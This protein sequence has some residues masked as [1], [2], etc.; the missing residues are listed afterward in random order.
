MVSESSP[1]DAPADGA[2]PVDGAAGGDAPKTFSRRQRWMSVLAKARTDTLLALWDELDERFE[3]ERAIWLR[4]P[5][6][7]LVMVRG[8]AGGSGAPFNMG[9]MTVTRCAARLGAFTGH[10]YIAGRKRRHAEVA[11][12]LDALL[13]DPSR[14]EELEDKVLAPLIADAESRDEARRRKAG[15]TKVD[16]FTMVRGE[17]E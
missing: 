4:R 11:A 14:T 6:A 5:E 17:D 10:A 3:A 2:Q 12:L 9:E 13:Q 1:Q 8:R 16:F 15:A 7:G